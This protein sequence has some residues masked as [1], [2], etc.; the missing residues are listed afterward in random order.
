[1]LMHETTYVFNKSVQQQ[2]HVQSELVRPIPLTQ[3]SDVH[4]VSTLIT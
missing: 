1:M 2:Q 4:R 3:T